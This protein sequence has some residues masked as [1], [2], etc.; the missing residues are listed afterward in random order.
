MEMELDIS[1]IKLRRDSE[2]AEKILKELWNM[3][4]EIKGMELFEIISLMEMPSYWQLMGKTIKNTGKMEYYY[5][6]L[7]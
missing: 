3:K 7:P 6:L 5:P 2:R 1:W 4:M